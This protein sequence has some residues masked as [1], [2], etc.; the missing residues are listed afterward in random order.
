MCCCV[1]TTS[2]FLE[3]LIAMQRLLSL[4]LLSKN[5]NTTNTTSYVSNTFVSLT[6]TNPLQYSTTTLTNPQLKPK[7]F[8]GFFANPVLVNKILQRSNAMLKAQSKGLL[9]FKWVFSRSCSW[10]KYQHYSSS[11][12]SHSSFR[13]NPQ[14]FVCWIYLHFFNF[15]KKKIFLFPLIFALSHILFVLF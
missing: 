7:I 11:Y 4:R 5:H 3:I 15:Q 8:F 2:A 1:C 12:N 13:Y 10:H 14:S 6:K 9:D